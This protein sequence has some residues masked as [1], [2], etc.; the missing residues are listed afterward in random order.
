M[1]ESTRHVER[2]GRG[3]RTIERGQQCGVCGNLTLRWSG[4]RLWAASMPGPDT[5]AVCEPCYANPWVQASRRAARRW[6]KRPPPGEAG[7]GSDVAA[8]SEDVQA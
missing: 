6:D 2:S 5:I 8:G 1:A 4:Q 7:Q 3:R